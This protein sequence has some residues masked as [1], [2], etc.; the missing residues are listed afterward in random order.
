MLEL[1]QLVHT[2]E[3]EEN[4]CRTLKTEKF[5]DTEAFRKWQD[6]KTLLRQHRN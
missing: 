2:G 3:F 1:D 4:A 5:K 6:Y